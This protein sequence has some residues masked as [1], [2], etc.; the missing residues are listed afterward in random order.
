MFSS[1]GL[2]QVIARFNI[3]W[4]LLP[5]LCMQLEQENQSLLKKVDNLEGMRMSSQKQL[6]QTERMNKE[7][8]SEKMQLEQLLHKAETMQE[9][10]EEELRVLRTEQ[11]ET[12]EELSQVCMR[13]DCSDPHIDTYRNVF[14]EL[15]SF[16]LFLGSSPAGSI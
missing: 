6:N 9:N 5:F 2:E 15:D 12:Q 4:L 11:K 7:L 3:H 8:H 13:A 16:S 14:L 10:L 1:D